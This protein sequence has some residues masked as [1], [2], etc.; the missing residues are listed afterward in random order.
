MKP[1]SVWLNEAIAISNVNAAAKLIASYLTKKTGKKF[2]ST[3]VIEHF[4]N[5][6]KKGFGLRWFFGGNR[7]IRFNWE[8]DS[9]HSASLSSVDF[10]ESNSHDPKWSIDFDRTVSLAQTLPFIKDLIKAPIKPGLYTMIPPINLNEDVED[11]D[12][13]VLLAESVQDDVF[14]GV[15]SIL[16]PGAI[17]KVT[18]IEKQFKSRGY[19]LITHIRKNWPQL[20]GKEGRD[21]T[22]VGNP[23]D[24]KSIA[25][26]KDKIIEALGGAKVTI[27]P[28]GSNEQYKMKDA[29]EA[30]DRDIERIAYEDQLN[31]LESLVRMTVRGSSNALFVGGRGG[32]GKTHTVEKVLASMGLQ[33]GAGYFKNAGSASAKGVYT[34]LFKNRDGIVLFDDSDGALA[35]QDGRNLFKAATDI[36]AVRKLAWNKSGGKMKD[37]DDMTDEDIEAGILPTHF[38]FTGRVIFIS[39]LS[40]DKLDPDGALRT[41]GY[42]IAIDPTDEEVLN[43]M[44]KISGTIELQDGLDMSQDKRNEV[45][46]MIAAGKKSDLNI[47]KLVRALNIRAA[48]GEDSD[49]KTMVK[50]YA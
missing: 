37:P 14:D 39:N 11:N 29:L 19:N 23:N 32:T 8:N 10:W 4:K 30:M 25:S 2:H 28:G 44:R 34:V 16:T 5:S 20:F 35:D 41:R 31:H 17:V 21:I 40:L 9:I 50:H 45:I 42:I 15:L 27:R 33:D 43:F 22:F 48:L 3:P 7:S 18:E 1:F 47:R 38:E 46:D 24:V 26:Q 6:Q 49:W 12:V 13:A 36:K